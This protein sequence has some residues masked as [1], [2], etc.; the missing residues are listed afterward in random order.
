MRSVL[1]TSDMEIHMSAR[2]K[3]YQDLLQDVP[4]F[5][6]RFLHWVAASSV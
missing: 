5:N 6:A 2:Y 4:V 1:T 3:R